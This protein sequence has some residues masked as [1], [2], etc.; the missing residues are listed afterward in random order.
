M[1]WACILLPQLALDG[2]LRRHATPDEPLALI[3]GPVQRRVLRAAN[4][5]AQAA[6]LR[7][8]QP[9]ATAQAICA[10]FTVVEH[11]P[12]ETARWHDFLA[13]W[14]YR[15]GAQVSRQLPAALLIEVE[16]SFRLFGPWP[17][18]EALMREEL[19]ALGFRH[20]IALAPNPWAARALAGVHDGL[21]ITHDAPLQRALGQL[22]VERAGLPPDAAGS[23]RR[24]GLRRLVQ[25]SALP[26]AAL[27]RRVGTD[28]LDQLDRLSGALATPLDCYQPPDHFE[29]RIEFNYEVGV[30]GQ[31]LFPLRRMTGD[32]A[33]YLAGR[34]G[35]VQRFVLRL[36]HDRGA[37]T[38]VPVGLL[39]P[40]RDAAMLFELARGRLDLVQLAAPV[41]ALQLIARELPPFVPAGRDLF[42][43]R[44]QQAVPWE[45]LRERLRARLG[46]SAVHGLAIHADHRPEH[47]WRDHG[48]GDTPPTIP[49]PGWLLAQPIPLRER[50]S[51]ILAGPERIESGWWD[52]DVR[53]D[54][55]LV[56]TTAGQRAWAFCAAGERG[57]FMLHGWFA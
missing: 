41:R 20:R 16:A 53:R 15:Y 35:G 6:G 46:D 28:T 38:E 32:L 57:G 39:A 47:A 13:A 42:D 2:V 21:A 55:Y 33:A 14:A 27:G 11:D 17:R 48:S 5:T 25:V 18:M 45:Q 54:Y 8:G 30:T 31:L 56:E 24:M 26:R 40:E 36:E 43:I 10:R 37:A 19:T 29:S 1:L 9:L 50:I 44:P 34:D 7:A 3:T 52:G 4:A 23:L 49:R 51:R 22:P 12:D